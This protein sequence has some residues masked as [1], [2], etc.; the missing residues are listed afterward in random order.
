[1]E[2]IEWR[3]DL[4]DSPAGR[5]FAYTFVGTVGG[6]PLLVAL[7]GL[8]ALP[9][10][11]VS[12]TANPPVLALVVV[13]ALVG[14]P[15]SLLY[16]WPLLTDPDQRA[17]LLA[18][19]WVDE[20]SARGV[21]A[22]TVLGALVHALGFYLLPVAPL[23]LLVLGGLLASTGT[24]LLL[25]EGRIDPDDRTLAVRS[26]LSDRDSR[27]RTVDLAAW[28]GLSRYRIGPVVLLRPRYGPGVRGGTPRLIPVPA[29]VA[30]AATPAF[31]A[32]LD[33]PAPEP[34]RPPNPAVAATLAVFGLGS[35]ALGVA[36][37]VL[38]VGPAGYRLY[39]LALASLFGAVFLAAAVRE[40]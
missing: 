10:V 37:A 6:L 5:L 18:D 34:E 9:V 39:L 29:T 27:G 7:V 38:E 32:A 20:L 12:L 28:T 19:T 15:L 4:E 17:P 13:L 26:A 35:V 23:L 30:A 25:T 2:P 11:I 1:M 31:E 16:L 8:L 36:I 22:S 21:L 14:G 24:W 3:R 40:Y 33:A